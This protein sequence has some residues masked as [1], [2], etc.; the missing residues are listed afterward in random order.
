MALA[1]LCRVADALLENVLSL[2]DK[3]AVQVDRVVRV[4]AGRI[5]L[6]EDELAG[7]LVVLLHLAAVL[8]ALVAQLLGGRAISVVVGAS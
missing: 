4:A 6:A 1:L 5:V 7:L 8:L 3:L 2:L